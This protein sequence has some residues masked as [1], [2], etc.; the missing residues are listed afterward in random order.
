MLAEGMS[1]ACFVH[2]VRVLARKIN[3]DHLRTENQVE[4]IL[5]DC[6]FFPYIVP[7]KATKITGPAGA[8]YR[9]ISWCQFSGKRHH[10]GHQIEFNS[11]PRHLKDVR[12]K[13]D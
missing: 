12:R 13:S 2:H 7:A 6:A 9:L 1:D 10:H 3:N 5:N 11:A 8:L 4:N